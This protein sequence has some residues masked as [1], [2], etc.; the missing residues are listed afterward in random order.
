M[1][2]YK[3]FLKIEGKKSCNSIWTSNQLLWKIWF[4]N[5]YEKWDIF[6]P[7]I[8]YSKSFK[9]VCVINLN[10][11]QSLIN[12]DY[13]NILFELENKTNQQ[14]FRIGKKQIY[15]SF[16]QSLQKLNTYWYKSNRKTNGVVSFL[17]K[18]SISYHNLC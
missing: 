5:L 1:L 2:K 10:K 14:I 8:D 4:M 18:L 6:A 16:R 9:K 7:E 17:A 11:K 13:H 3:D 15:W 12:C